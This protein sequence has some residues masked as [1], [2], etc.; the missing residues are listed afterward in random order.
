LTLFI[1]ASA[2]IA[3]IAGEADGDV[4][5]DV[6]ASDTDGLWS[7]MSCWEAVSGLRHSHK[8]SAAQARREVEQA[9]V[10]LDLRLVG[11]DAPELRMA[12]DAH[13]RF[14][15]G[16]G[17]PAKLNMGDCFAYACAKTN[18]ARLLYKGDDFIHT[19]LA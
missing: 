15:R 19:D 17:H 5:L 8:Y 18:N 3:I 14:G 1:D 6:I 2:L 4:L 13:Q 9:A 11:I 10:D 16:S 12:L 7:P